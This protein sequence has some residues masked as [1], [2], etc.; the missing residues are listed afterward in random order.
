MAQELKYKN[1]EILLDETSNQLLFEVAPI[2][3]DIPYYIYLNNGNLKLIYIYLMFTLITD[4]LTPTIMGFLEN[5]VNQY[6]PLQLLMKIK[7]TLTF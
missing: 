3:E 5:G 6:L 1:S 2:V 7:L 4:L